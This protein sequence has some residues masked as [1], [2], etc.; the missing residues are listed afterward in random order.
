[1]ND[2]PIPRWTVRYNINSPE[3]GRW[4]GTGWEF[5]DEGK[6]ASKA[7]ARHIDCGNVPTKR[8]F[9]ANDT[10]YLGACHGF[11]KGDR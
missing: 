11:D 2:M 3:A 9:H 6:D 1:M 7:Y 10:K 5:F 8:P 4:I